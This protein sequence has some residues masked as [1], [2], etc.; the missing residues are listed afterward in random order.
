MLMLIG[1]VS[2]S[3][4]QRWVDFMNSRQDFDRAHRSSEQIHFRVQVTRVGIMIA[5]RPNGPIG[6]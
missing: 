6:A 5:Q 1:R 4:I 3:D 2:E